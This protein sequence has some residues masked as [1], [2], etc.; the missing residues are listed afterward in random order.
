VSK[1]VGGQGRPYGSLIAGAILVVLGAL[2]MLDVSNVLE[3]RLNVVLP[4]ILIVIGLALVFGARNGPHSGLV[5]W[6]LLISLAVVAAATVPLTAFSGGIGERDFRVT[7]QAQL[8]SNYSVGVGDLRLDLSDL[9]L[10]ESASVEVSVGAGELRVVLPP[11]VSVDIEASSGAGEIVLLGDSRNGV[12]V[13]HSYRS[14]GYETAPV[15]LTLDLRTA[16]GKIEVS[17]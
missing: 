9:D 8:E 6:G 11:D 17:R 12:G 13:R 16:A 3:L 15:T 5:V 10:V 14:E 7:S 2:W 4:A 1:P